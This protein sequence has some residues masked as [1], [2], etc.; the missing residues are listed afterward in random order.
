MLPGNK[1]AA[2][3]RGQPPAVAKKRPAARRKRPVPLDS[4]EAFEKLLKAADALE[5]YQLRLYVTGTSFR[6]SQAIANIRSLCD[7]YLK[8]RYSLEVV[9]IY[10]QPEEAVDRQI[11]AAPTLV[12]ESPVPLKR[13]VGD[14]SDRDKVLIGLNLAKDSKETTWVHV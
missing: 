4:A 1:H 14:L 7:E 11:I 13:M 5:H 8:G 12:K 3:T 6:S 2:A 10:Q 9:D